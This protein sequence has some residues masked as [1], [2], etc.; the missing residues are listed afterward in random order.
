[1][2]GSRGDCRD[3]VATQR[4]VDVA[5]AHVDS[6]RGDAMWMVR[7]LSTDERWPLDEDVTTQ[8]ASVRSCWLDRCAKGRPG[9]EVSRQAVIDGRQTDGSREMRSEIHQWPRLV[10][11]KHA[12]AVLNPVRVALNPHASDYQKTSALG[13]RPRRRAFIPQ[14]PTLF[15]DGGT[16]LVTAFQGWRARRADFE[17]GSGSETVRHRAVASRPRG[18]SPPS[19]DDSSPWAARWPSPRMT[20]R[21]ACA[22]SRPV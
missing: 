22:G 1:M 14:G 19:S 17:N 16:T 20:C 5:W 4:H 2:H 9:R 21:A 6:V 12:R 13:W 3:I 15:G 11:A 7:C 18:W 8:S 10:F